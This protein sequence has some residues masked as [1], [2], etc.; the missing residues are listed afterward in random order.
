M[1]E[2]ALAI[3]LNNGEYPKFNDN[4][5][6]NFDIDSIIYYATSYLNKTIIKEVSIKNLLS[7]IYKKNNSN[8]VEIFNKNE[9]KF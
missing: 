1:K 3:K 9:E 7:S 6:L 8:Q 4:L 5:D 2:W